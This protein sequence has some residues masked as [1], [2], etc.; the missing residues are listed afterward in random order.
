LA[1]AVKLAHFIAFNVTTAI[2]NTCM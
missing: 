2:T 1:K